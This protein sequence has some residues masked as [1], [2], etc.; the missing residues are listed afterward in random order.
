MPSSTLYAA[1]V[2]LPPKPPPKTVTPI[3]LGG[4][5]GRGV[6]TGLIQAGVKLPH[7]EPAG[8]SRTRLSGTTKGSS[9][10][11]LMVVL[12]EGVAVRF[13]PWVGGTASSESVLEASSAM[14]PTL[15]ERG[16]IVVS[17][18]EF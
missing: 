6:V 1:G 8:I 4:S 5:F 13:C 10:L 16:R 11:F 17:T 12:D 7:R 9:L 2:K 18:M 14:W 3:G 15:S